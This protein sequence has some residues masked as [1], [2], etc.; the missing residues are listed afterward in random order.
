[1]TSYAPSQVTSFGWDSPEPRWIMGMTW[2]ATRIYPEAM[3]EVDMTEE[4]YTFFGEMY[5]MKRQSI[6]DDIMPR[7]RMDV[8]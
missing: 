3:A 7:V 5:G 1:M 2:L 4:L 8:Q 6:T